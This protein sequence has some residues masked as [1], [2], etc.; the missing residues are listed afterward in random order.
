MVSF[1]DPGTSLSIRIR[2]PE[3]LLFGDLTASNAHAILIQTELAIESSQHTGS[4]SVVCSLSNL[5]AKSKSQE[6]YRRQLPQW[7]LRPCDVEI[8]MKEVESENRVQIN[9]D[10]NAVN[11]H[12]SPGIVYTLNEVSFSRMCNN[13]TN[14]QKLIDCVLDN[15]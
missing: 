9:V 6:R 2:K 1:F 8:S 14:L 5:L 4:S 10:V 7:V 13:Y 3:I 15:L 12:I 11:I